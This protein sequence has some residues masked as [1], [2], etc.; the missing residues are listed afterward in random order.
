ML[1]SCIMCFIMF[2]LFKYPFVV[3]S[4]WLKSIVNLEVRRRNVWKWNISIEPANS[5]RVLLNYSF[6]I[7]A[8]CEFVWCI[9]RSDGSFVEA[10]IDWG[11][12]IR[13]CWNTVHQIIIWTKISSGRE[14][15]HISSID[16]I[17]Q[18]FIFEDYS[19][20]NHGRN[21]KCFESASKN[22][23]TKKCNLRKIYSTREPRPE[24]TISWVFQS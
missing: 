3:V 24:S 2:I 11:T 17:Q 23:S 14:P 10:L 12:S 13:R 20:H 4:F 6:A 22:P 7:S 16:E 21:S 5:S 18:H 1:L 19:D 8:D 9:A 15:F